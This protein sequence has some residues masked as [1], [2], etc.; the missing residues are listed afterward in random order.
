MANHRFFLRKF[1][2]LDGSETLVNKVRIN[3]A[4]TSLCVRV[5]EILVYFAVDLI[6]IFIEETRF[7]IALI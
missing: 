4:I 3:K 7:V 6:S 5:A 1:L 2:V